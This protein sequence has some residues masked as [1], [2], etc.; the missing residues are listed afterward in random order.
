MSTGHH[1]K[2]V[3]EHNA[4]TGAHQSEHA[5]STGGTA[6]GGHGL[7]TTPDTVSHTQ[8][9]RQRMRA[10]NG[11]IHDAFKG[12]FSEKTAEQ[13]ALTIT[14]PLLCI[15]SVL[16]LFLLIFLIVRRRQ[17]KAEL[18]KTPLGAPSDSDHDPNDFSGVGNASPPAA[19][20]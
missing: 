7:H 10:I 17:L 4:T 12:S 16:F 2:N 5:Q 8:T 19:L 13:K 18:N 3:T 15:V 20:A 6:H 9:F 14:L 11:H 1:D